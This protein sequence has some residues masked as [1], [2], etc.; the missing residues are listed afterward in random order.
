MS[1]N[2]VGNPYSYYNNRN[3]TGPL[4]NGFI[5]V[6]E[7]DLD[8]TIIAN[9]KQVTA[10]QEDGT[11]VPITQP[12]RTN[13]GGYAV[14]DVGNLI[15]LLVNGN[16]SIR[17]NDKQRNLAL[18]QADVN[19]GV[20]LTD[21]D[22]GTGQDQIETNALRDFKS[23]DSLTSAITYV[24]ANPDN[25][26]RLDTVSRR[27][28]IEC[29]EL[30]IAYPD[31][32]GASY[33]VG[34]GLGTTD[35][36]S[37]INAGSAQ[38]KL[39]TLGKEA[40]NVSVFGVIAG[41]G[42]TSLITSALEFCNEANIFLDLNWVTHEVTG[43]SLTGGRDDHYKI[44]NGSILSSSTNPLIISGT[45][46]LTGSLAS[47][48]AMGGFVV[49]IAGGVTAETGDILHI[50]S[51]TPWYQDDRGESFTGELTSIK[52]VSAQSITIA[53][54]TNDS[55][56]IPAEMVSIEV[57]S[58]PRVTLLDIGIESANS[59]D[60]GKGV[61]LNYCR[62]ILI[63]NTVVSNARTQGVRIF[64]CYKGDIEGGSVTG[65]NAV[66]TG[67]GS[68]CSNSTHINYRKVEFSGC[69]RGIDFSGFTPSRFCGAYN[70]VNIGG[71]KQSTGESYWNANDVIAGNPVIRNSGFGNHGPS[72]YCNTIS[73]ITA[74]IHT[75]YLDRGR[76][77]TIDDNIHY[78]GAGEDTGII[79]S[80]HSGGGCY[81][82]NKHY[83][84]AYAPGLGGDGVSSDKNIDYSIAPECFIRLVS[85][86]DMQ[87]PR[88][89]SGN[90]SDAVRSGIVKLLGNFYFSEAE[91]G[92]RFD[93]DIRNNEV[94]ICRNVGAEADVATALIFERVNVFDIEGS[95]ILDNNRI[96]RGANF[97]GSIKP[98]N[99]SLLYTGNSDTA[100]QMGRS[101]A[102]VKFIAN[103][104]VAGVQVNKQ[105]ALLL[106]V[107]LNMVSAGSGLSYGF[108]GLLGHEG[109]R[110]IPQGFD[111]S[112]NH[113]ETV[114]AGAT[115]AVGDV[116]T[117]WVGDTL[118][119]ENR[120]GGSRYAYLEV[121][122]FSV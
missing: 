59:T 23:F 116:T 115:G 34:I 93:L 65:S 121:C 42:N 117:A 97:T 48:V 101:R 89:I 105:N 17:V 91:N 58:A 49:N 15:V 45:S 75:P 83:I 103:N 43:I 81:T 60:S 18:E 68:Q 100:I 21:A 110:K 63:K 24:A 11:Q 120:T 40:I 1:L 96:K 26:K 111:S 64:K 69:R 61:T 77:S 32:G 104:A 46:V 41:A 76:S 54:A 16:Y 109:V 106:S 79:D 114:P 37:I 3:K 74:N 95:I 27:N 62:D 19:D 28:E 98:S 52:S 90:T 118:Y 85:N 66:A 56:A 36:G 25:I 86:T 72:E 82:N 44:R 84:S 47:S 80:Q 14:D 6:G 108:S 38:L 87:I 55:Y 122:D 70:C 99:S 88:R 51:N 113:I 13:S 9:Q 102:F 7:P 5:Y 39:N 31:A 20:P 73:C 78:G 107:K 71:G 57:F 53:D 10:K 12:I 50:Q 67:Y 30:G 22:I 119:I 2:F 8:P 29:L 94:Q 4:F 112:H 33:V 35:G 92:R